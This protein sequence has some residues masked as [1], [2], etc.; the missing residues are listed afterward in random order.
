MGY[1][2]CMS[3][4]R[5]RSEDASDETHT[6]ARPSSRRAPLGAI[7]QV[8]A[9]RAAPA[10][11]RLPA[12]GAARCVVG[13]GSGADIV[14]QDSAVS[15][16]HVELALVPEG[17]LA[18]DLGSR[19]GTFYLGHRFER[20]VLGFGSIIRLG[21]V[22]VRID[23][24]TEGLDEGVSDAVGAGHRG[25][26]GVSPAM[27]R[28][29][30][31]LSRLEGSLVSVLVEGETGSGKELVAHAIHEGSAVSTGPLVV[32]NCGAI[33]RE[34]VLSELFGHKR[35]AFTGAQVDRRGAFEAADGGTLFLDEVG[36][37]PLEAQP[38]LL[39]ALES[40]EIRPVGETEP[41]KVRT[42]IIAATNRDLEEEVRAGRF[43]E[44]LYYRLAVVKIAMVPLR[45]RRD[46]IPLLAN[47]FAAAAGLPALPEDVV[48]ALSAHSW[49]GNVRELR[50]AVQAYIA[51]GAVPCARGAEEGRLE[52]SLRDLID[53]STPY[54]DLKE[55]FLNRFSR[56]YLEMLLRAT[57]G[58]QS[59]AARISG[60]DRSH[61]GRMLVRQGITR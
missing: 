17:V 8:V 44:D 13:A 24:D 31:V 54:A 59:E 35:G 47:H 3:H 4:V 38:A 20:M 45:E 41:R 53:V 1:L 23:V 56:I 42:R 10:R 30:A 40:G 25:L 18:T 28:L 27:R 12:T 6:V 16:S 26:L 7:V 37:L 48:V 39:R 36:E 33:A 49:P 11:F 22:D 15:R 55:E 50:N 21:T 57:N 9:A 5:P 29:Y 58:N 51:I 46:D 43:R 19:N 52:Q 32:M 2:A 34:L 14:I 61:L 60:L